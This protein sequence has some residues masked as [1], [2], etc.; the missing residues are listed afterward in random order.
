MTNLKN[1][2][3]LITGATGDFGK[4][5][6]KKFDEAGC[7]LL[8]WGRNQKKLDALQKSLNT[9]TY[10]VCCDI[11][12]P[13]NIK[14]AWNEIPEDWKNIDILINNAGGALGLSPIYD[15]EL[16]DLNTMIQ[17]NVTSL[18]TL[19]N[20]VLSKMTKRK[21]G[22]IINIGSI[23]G[24]Y[25]Y[26]G[27]HIYCASKAFVKMYSAAAR[28][29]LIDQNIRITNIEPGIVET[30]FSMVRFKGDKQKADAVYANAN[31]LQAEDIA[32][33]VF[34]VASQP[35]HICVTSMEIMP[36]TQGAGALNVHR[37][38]QA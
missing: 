12:D 35:P 23:A 8:L 7:R 29:D 33:N 36:T 28:A 6:C 11:T 9:E 27:G 4:A 18:V 25:P 16:D 31:A 17:I 37:K 19:T 1:K 2:T 20:F 30:Q 24:N 26:P 22:H 13:D 10:T 15:A 38:K 32:E 21:T 3:T 34:W 5:F 14:K